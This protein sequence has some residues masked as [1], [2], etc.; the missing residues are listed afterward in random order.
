M[1]EIV[2]KMRAYNIDPSNLGNF[3]KESCCVVDRLFGIQ[4]SQ[5]RFCI[6]IEKYIDYLKGNASFQGKF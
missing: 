2:S 1:L 6:I 3:A 5:A 4:F